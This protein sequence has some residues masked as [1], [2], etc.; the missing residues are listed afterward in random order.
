MNNVVIIYQRDKEEMRKGK[1]R[2][3]VSERKSERERRFEKSLSE[4]E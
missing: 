1:R 3:K 2:K 4:S